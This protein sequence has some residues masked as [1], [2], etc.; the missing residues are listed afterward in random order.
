MGLSKTASTQSSNAKIKSN[1]RISATSRNNVNVSQATTA[2]NKANSKSK[3]KTDAK[4]AR[5]DGNSL[6]DEDDSFERATIL[7]SPPKG[8]QRLSSVVSHFGHLCAHFSSK[9]II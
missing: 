7:E 8:A 5:R 6:S 3:P 2:G 1:S 9:S 4:A